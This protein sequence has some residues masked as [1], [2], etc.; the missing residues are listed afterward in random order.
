MCL[1]L[2]KGCHIHIGFSLNRNNFRY[3]IWRILYMYNDRKV[4]L[5]NRSWKSNTSWVLSYT[6]VSSKI[7]RTHIRIKPPLANPLTY[8]MY[9]YMYTYTLD[10]T[11]LH[12]NH[13]IIIYKIYITQQLAYYISIKYLPY[14]ILYKP[15]TWYFW[16]SEVLSWRGEWTLF[17]THLR[18]LFYFVFRTRSICFRI[19]Y[20][21]QM[22]LVM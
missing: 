5:P 21:L 8:N 18:L 13:Q 14:Q 4:L 10:I 2:H 22:A 3:K 16:C 17:L 15:T 9:M 6:S 1:D 12:K 20:R 7:G 19:I 11:N